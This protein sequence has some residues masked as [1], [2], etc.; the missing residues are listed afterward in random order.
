VSRRGPDTWLVFLG[1]FLVVW[2][3]VASVT[4][5]SW[6]WEIAD[7]AGALVG[8]WALKRFA[9]QVVAWLSTDREDAP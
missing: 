7:I 3:V 5:D 8:A 2:G 4:A 6:P 1:T 9:D